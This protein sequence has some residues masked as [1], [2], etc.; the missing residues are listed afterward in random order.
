VLVAGPPAAAPL[1]AVAAAGSMR[2]AKAWGIQT[3]AQL[4]LR[5]RLVLVVV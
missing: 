4:L 3:G 1:P 2:A 5:V